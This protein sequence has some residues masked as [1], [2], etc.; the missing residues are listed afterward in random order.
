[1][2]VA[3][4]KRKSMAQQSSTDRLSDTGSVSNMSVHRMS[5]QE[6]NNPLASRRMTLAYR[7]G[8]GTS[9]SSTSKF[10]KLENTYA[11]GP[12]PNEKF[13]SSKVGL[14]AM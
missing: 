11:L 10:V 14:G 2:S 5:R 4:S 3:S 13:D 9:V 6:F 7:R 1:M 8:S 12:K